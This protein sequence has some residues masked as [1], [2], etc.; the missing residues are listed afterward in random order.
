[1]PGGRHQESI[2]NSSPSSSLNHHKDHFDV[3]KRVFAGGAIVLL[4]CYYLGD[5]LEINPV[6]C[7]PCR[8]R[9]KLFT[10]LVLTLYVVRQFYL[11]LWHW[12]GSQGNPETVLVLLPRVLRA[13]RTLLYF[14]CSPFTARAVWFAVWSSDRDEGLSAKQFCGQS[15]EQILA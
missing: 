7:F 2:N 1:M 6:L 8:A 11:S 10:R 15:G 9:A 12:P 3:R 14:S 4:W 5:V 13:D